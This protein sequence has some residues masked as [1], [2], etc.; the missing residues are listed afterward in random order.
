M[1]SITRVA[2]SALLNYYTTVRKMGGAGRQDRYKLLVAWMYYELKHNSDYL[3]EPEIIRDE[4]GSIA[5]CN[6]HI[7]R[8]AE[9]DLEKKYRD[10]LACL[11]SGSCFIH[12]L[13]DD[14]C[15]P[16]VEVICPHQLEERF[17]ILVADASEI[18]VRLSDPD[19]TSIEGIVNAYDWEENSALFQANDN[20]EEGYS[21]II[22]LND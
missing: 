19:G 15:I 2:Q 16:V 18:G 22:G 21:N 13:P 9:L 4:D 6:W 11:T 20:E 14:E 8:K 12:M 1:D 3:Q 17:R 7:D 10:N 5:S